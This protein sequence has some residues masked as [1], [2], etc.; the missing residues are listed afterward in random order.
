MRVCG[1]VFMLINHTQQSG[2]FLTCGKLIRMVGQAVPGSSLLALAAQVYFTPPIP[3]KVIF[4][5]A[6]QVPPCKLVVH[7]HE[8]EHP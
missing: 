3:I 1:A 7:V 2:Y 5:R 6:A 8:N 4:P